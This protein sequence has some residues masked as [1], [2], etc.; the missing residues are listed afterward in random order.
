MDTI[1]LEDA[2][3]RTFAETERRSKYGNVHTEYNGRIYHSA[4]EAE[5]A[6]MLDTL[7]RATDDK[8]R[9]IRVET[10][11]PFRIRVKGK[12]ICKYLLDFKVTYADGRVEYVD[13]KGVRTDVYK[14]KK[15]LVEALF[16][17]TIIET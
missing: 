12:P 5:Y 14:L 6:K 2:M 10:Q 15:K 4:K 8:D 3:K 7:R 11:V 17:V 1:S 16:P 13:V 9:V